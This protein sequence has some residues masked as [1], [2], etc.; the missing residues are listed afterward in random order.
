LYN[1]IA[2]VEVSEFL[3]N[4]YNLS[5]SEIP[6]VIVSGP[7]PKNL[8]LERVGEDTLKIGENV[9]LFLSASRLIAETKIN[10]QVEEYRKLVDNPIVKFK[11]LSKYE[12]KNGNI[13]DRRGSYM[14]ME[15]IKKV[16]DSVTIAINK[17]EIK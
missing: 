2:Y 7:T 16:I 1:T 17:S 12:V 6:V 3:R 4:D 10:Q 13:V 5:K 9:L 15:N 11:I 14:T 8:I